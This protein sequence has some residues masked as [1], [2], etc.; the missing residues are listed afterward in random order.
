MS[1][2]QFETEL[3]QLQGKLVSLYGEM[4]QLFL[5]HGDVAP[6]AGP[7]IMPHLEMAKKA[8]EQAVKPVEK[9]TKLF[10]PGD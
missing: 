10:D 6:Q 3:K 5:R 1:K 7:K 9:P 4:Q 2:L 8:V